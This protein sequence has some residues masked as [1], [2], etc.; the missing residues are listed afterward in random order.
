MKLS[1]IK[2][3]ESLGLS[4]K[5]HCLITDDLGQTLLDKDNAIHP[6]NMARIIARGLANQDHSWIDLIAFGNGGTEVDSVLTI[7]YKTPNDGITDGMAYASSLYNETYS[8]NVTGVLGDDSDNSVTSEEVG[9]I[10]KVIVKATI[11]ADQPGGQFQSD[12]LSPTEVLEGTFTFDELGLFSTGL[13]AAETAGYQDVDFDTDVNAAMNTQLV[14][15][16]TYSFFCKIDNEVGYPE[17]IITAT[18]EYG[19]VV[20]FQSVITHINNALSG[21][22]TAGVTGDTNNSLTYGNLRLTSNETGSDSSVYIVDV[23][24]EAGLSLT[25]TADKALFSVEGIAGYQNINDA[26]AGQ[27]AGEIDN[28]LNQSLERKRMLTHLIFSPITKTAN[29]TIKITYTL[30]VEVAQSI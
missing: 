5:G 30:T 2:R 27:D 23:T 13:P 8:E 3:K 11:A 18:P 25:R 21:V 22:A 12:N 10:S 1:N 6:Q 14:A 15:G 20:T 19:N 26:V 17:V 9:T 4:V 29:R 24:E 16:T 7:T 28:S